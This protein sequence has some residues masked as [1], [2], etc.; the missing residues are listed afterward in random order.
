MYGETSYGK[1]S[2]SRVTNRRKYEANFDDIRF[3]SRC[4]LSQLGGPARILY[5]PLFVSVVS[6]VGSVV[7]EA[8]S[9]HEEVSGK[10]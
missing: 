6:G 2:A 5:V 1:G 4:R 7:E 9:K 10:C 8:S 3:P